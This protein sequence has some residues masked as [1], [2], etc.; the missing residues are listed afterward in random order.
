MDELMLDIDENSAVILDGTEHSVTIHDQKVYYREGTWCERDDDGEL[1]PDWGLTWFYTNKEHPE[2][3][4]YYE[5]DPPETA[6][7]NLTSILAPARE[8]AVEVLKVAA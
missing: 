6:I 4:L 8:A 2:N 7:H 3:Y 1:M 5:Q